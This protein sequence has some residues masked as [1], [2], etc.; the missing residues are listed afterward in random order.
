VVLVM[1]K[2]IHATYGYIPRDLADVFS[3]SIQTSPL[4]PGA[5]ALADLAPASC[6]SFVLHAP[7]STIERRYVMAVALRALVPGGAL[8]VLA[9]KDKG[10]TRL[11]GELEAFGCVV[12]ESHKRHHR[13]VVTVR[14]DAPSGIAAAIEAGAPRMLPDLG[15]WSQPGLFNW[16]RIDPG[17][18]LLLDHLPVLGGR[19]ADLGCGIG[20]LAMAVCAGEACREMTLIDID[21]RALAV[22]ERNVW[23]FG[24]KTLWTDVRSA[25]NLPTGLDFVVTNPPFHDGGEEDRALGQAF[26]Q[27]AATMLRPGGVLWLT[28]NRHLPYEATLVPL[29]ATVDQVAQAKG[30]KIYSAQKETMAAKTHARKTLPKKVRL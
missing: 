25:N 17:S 23:G 6:A 15:I 3:G 11:S 19:G 5:T 1:T 24:A 22:A 28:A 30:F 18:Q 26:I 10:G 27:K 2:P 21:A 9:A 20:I 7:A 29:F 12:N 4:V 16:D 14:P 13:I 8:T